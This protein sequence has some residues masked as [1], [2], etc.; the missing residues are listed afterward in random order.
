MWVWRPTSTVMYSCST[1]PPP[2]L[3]DRSRAMC[4]QRLYLRDCTYR[5][6]RCSHE[7][8]QSLC[9][10]TSPRETGQYEYSSPGP[11]QP[12]Y[13]AIRAEVD[14][15][16]YNIGSFLSAISLNIVSQDVPRNWRHAVLSQFAL[17]GAAII[18]WVFLPESPRWHCAKGRKEEAQRILTKINGKVE[19]YD[20]ELEYTRMLLEIEDTRV[21]RMV[22]G[23]G[24]NL[25]RPPLRAFHRPVEL[26]V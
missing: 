19:G 6:T 1:D 18:A 12:Q 13:C 2:G 4:D 14:G 3:L 15:A 25:V 26:H 9:K 11:V 23:G 16:Q 24:T 5:W 20:V 17:S 8:C 10:C 21:A 22:Q 7:S